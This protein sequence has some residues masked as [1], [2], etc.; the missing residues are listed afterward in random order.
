MLSR[1]D[2]RNYVGYKMGVQ[3]PQWEGAHIGSDCTTAKHRISGDWYELWKNG[4]TYL[5]V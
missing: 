2:P 4:L 1:V 3:M 5:N